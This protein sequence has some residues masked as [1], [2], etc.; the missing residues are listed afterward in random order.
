MTDTTKQ[1]IKDIIS[2]RY[3]EKKSTLCKD[4]ME[5]FIFGTYGDNQHYSIDEI[6][7][8]YDEV[9]LEKNPLPV[10]EE[11]IEEPIIEEEIVVE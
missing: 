8:I 5:G 6:S 1:D 9:Y 2:E 10:I 7:A 4:I 11:V 3:D